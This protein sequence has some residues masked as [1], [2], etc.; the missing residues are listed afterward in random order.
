MG[1]SFSV[2]TNS[3]KNYINSNWG[4]L[5]CSPIGPFLQSSGLAP[6]DPKQTSNQCQSNSFSSQFNSSMTDQFKATSKLNEGFGQLSGSINNIRNMLVTIQ[7]QSYKD[8]SNVAD[9]LF[10]IYVKIGNI[11]MV[12]NKNLMNILNVFKNLVNLGDAFG[13]LIVSLINFIR[14]M[15]N[16]I[17]HL[18]NSFCF[19]KNTLIQLKNGKLVKMK[20]IK[21]GDV[22]INGSIVNGVLNLN[23]VN[24]EYFYKLKKKN[25]KYIYVTGSHYI[26]NKKLNK[27][28]F[29]KDHPDAQLSNKKES[30]FSC[31]ITNDHKIVIDDYTFWD[32]EDELLK[33]K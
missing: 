18:N 17:V 20:N 16:S 22:L 12:I 9:M 33:N 31:L 23:N 8:L 28:V 5:K 14:P 26:Y 13:I 7:Q 32:W 6:G 24:D 2:I 27:Y 19:N 11:I 29:V 4:D 10:G 25:G 1:N 30:E 21:L 3:N 15:I